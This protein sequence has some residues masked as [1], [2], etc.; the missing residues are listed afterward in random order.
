M[1]KQLPAPTDDSMGPAMRALTEKQQAFVTAFLLAGDGNAT[2]AARA[3]GYADTQGL[4]VTAFRL[5]RDDKVQSALV[6]EGQKFVTSAL[7]IAA[8]GLV[9]M[10]KN[11]G[12]RDH[13]RACDRILQQAGLVATIKHKHEHQH[14]SEEMIARIKTLAGQLKVDVSH[15]LGGGPIID[16]TPEKE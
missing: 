7:P 4:K 3:A 9:E 8:R 12:H 10:A 6:E 16:V 13:Y 5:M 15:L 1:T 11:P 14:S 2:A